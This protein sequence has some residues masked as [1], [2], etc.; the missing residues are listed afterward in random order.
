MPTIWGKL[1][2]RVV[3]R[4][5]SFDSAREAAAMLREYKLA[6]GAL[7]GQRMYGRWKLWIGKKYPLPDGSP[8]DEVRREAQ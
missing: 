5:D 4:I 7:P 2:D 8:W 3:E 6:F 1:D